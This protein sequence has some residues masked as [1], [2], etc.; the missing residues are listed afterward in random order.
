[1]NPNDL[2]A[3]SRLPI[4]LSREGRVELLV[5]AAHQLMAAETE[6]GLFLG[7]AVLAWLEAEHGDLCRDF[8]K[9][10][11]KRGSHRTPR[12]ICRELQRRKVARR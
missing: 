6:D 9:V 5:R 11:A 1:M 8:L 7:G 2:L 4:A 3:G 12:S 10:T